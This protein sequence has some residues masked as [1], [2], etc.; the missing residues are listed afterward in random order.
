MG[1]AINTGPYWM[2]LPRAFPALKGTFFRR[3]RETLTGVFYTVVQQFVIKVAMVPFLK[4]VYPMIFAS[5][6]L[7]L[8]MYTVEPTGDWN[9]TFTTFLLRPR[10]SRQFSLGLTKAKK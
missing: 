3:F 5:L 7:Q 10:G 4:D 6:F 1:S 9:T 8:A 2:L